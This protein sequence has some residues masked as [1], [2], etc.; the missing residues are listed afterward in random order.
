MRR[1]LAWV[2]VF[3]IALVICAFLFSPL[4]AR[5]DAARV[6]R[7][8]EPIFCWSRWVALIPL[9]A[10]RAF[11]RG[12]LDGG[13]QFYDGFGYLLTAKHR[14]A[15]LKYAEGDHAQFDSGVI[16]RFYLPWY[17]RFDFETSVREIE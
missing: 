2:A 14:I 8:D 1:K 11:Q 6:A 5:F 15:P 10:T 13:T 17:D 9:P 12:L 3:I 16:V 4:L 7:H